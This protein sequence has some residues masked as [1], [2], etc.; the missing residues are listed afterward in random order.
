MQEINTM[1]AEYSEAQ[2]QFF[3]YIIVLVRSVLA[4]IYCLRVS[5]KSLE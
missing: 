3:L 5:R 2:L 1:E 4:L